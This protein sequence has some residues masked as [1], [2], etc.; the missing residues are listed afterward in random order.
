MMSG[1]IL[2]SISTQE[3]ARIR[4]A[5]LLG[6]ARQPLAT[7]EQLRSLLAAAPEREPALAV[8]ALAGQRQRFAR[9]GGGHRD[10]DTPEAAQ[11]LHEDRRPILPAPAR[12]LL[13]RLANGVDKAMADAVIGAAVRRVQRAGFR[14]HPFDLPRLIGHIKGDARCLGLAERAYLAL[15][16]VSGKPEAPGLLHTEITTENWTGFPKAHRVAFLREERRKDAA[17]AR[18]L[19]ESVLRSEPAAVRADLLAALD[20]GLGSDDLPLLESLI[21]DRSE[22]VR[23]TAALL[24]T[25][26]PGTPGYAARLAEA[27]QCFAAASPGIGSVL[28]RVGLKGSGAVVFTPPKAA[29][30]AQQQNAVRLLFQGF[31][32]AEVAAAAGVGADAVLEAL[33]AGA[34]AVRNAFC[35]RAAHDGDEETMLRLVAHRL[36]HADTAW[37]PLAPQLAWLADSLSGAVSPEFGQA[38]LA[39]PAWRVVLEHLKEATTPAAMKDDGTL[40][41]TA[42][43]LPPELLPA[44][45]DAIAAL[46]PVTTRSALDLADLVLALDAC[47]LAKGD[48]DG[49]D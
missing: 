21:A 28:K 4:Q 32:L 9:P 44:F 41:W 8:L 34:E 23:N 49:K 24:S 29:R 30:A 13:T 36:V 19:L 37:L 6:L 2:P 12:R 3:L 10:D 42:A 46:L 22:N 1:P 14:L 38:L 45:R 17:A 43:I 48:I 11:R 40:V 39:S 16:E 47:K 20:V 35:E 26:V 33:P 25:R 18:A 31:S 27:A 7:P 15:A 5:F